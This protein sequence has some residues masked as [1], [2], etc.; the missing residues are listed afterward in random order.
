M[1]DLDG[2]N[3]DEVLRRKI[4]LVARRAKPPMAAAMSG[5][6]RTEA[7]V[8]PHSAEECVIYRCSRTDLSKFYF[9]GQNC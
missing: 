9:S 2:A 3:V 6:Q 5:T 4:K 8:A 7:D 1:V